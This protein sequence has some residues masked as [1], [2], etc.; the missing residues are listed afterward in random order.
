MNTLEECK[1]CDGKGYY[2]EQVGEHDCIQVQCHGC[3]GKGYTV[4]IKG[5][6][7]VEEIIKKYRRKK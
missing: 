6:E 3:Y 7:R 1:Q 4:T 5:S 2:P